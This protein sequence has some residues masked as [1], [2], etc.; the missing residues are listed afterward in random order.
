MRSFFQQQPGFCLRLLRG[1]AAFFFSFR[2]KSQLYNQSSTHSNSHQPRF[3]TLIEGLNEVRELKNQLLLRPGL[4]IINVIPISQK[5]TPK[6][7]FVFTLVKGCNASFG[8]NHR[9]WG[10]LSFI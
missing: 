4:T 3:L 8:K 2:A 1:L 9:F 10:K 7:P 5:Y 6:K